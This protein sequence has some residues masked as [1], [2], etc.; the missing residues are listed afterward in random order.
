M[1]HLVLGFTLLLTS[2]ASAIAPP[3]PA[4]LEAMQKQKQGS[5]ALASVPKPHGWATD[6]VYLG[7]WQGLSTAG[8]AVID[9][10]TV[11][12]NRVR[13]GNTANGICDS[14]Y[15]VQFLPWGR[16]GTFPHQLSPPLEPT[17]LIYGVV[18]LTLKPKPCS[19]GV[20]VIQLAMPLDG[21]QAPDVVTLDATGQ[22]NGYFGA[23][24]PYESPPR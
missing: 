21:S 13:W 23:F 14:D 18:Q 11:E 5:A 12:P 4:D 22:P 16:N 6:N 17:D 10:L 15:A 7:R 1:K 3:T 20:A 9:V 2:P 8:M 19:T 24:Q